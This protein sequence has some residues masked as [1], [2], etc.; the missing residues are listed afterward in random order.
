MQRANSA[1][2]QIHMFRSRFWAFKR[3]T[4]NDE[5]RKRYQHGFGAEAQTFCTR[6]ATERRGA[7]NGAVKSEARGAPDESFAR[8]RPARGSDRVVSV[9]R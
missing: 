8:S 5:V 1:Q 9:A 2:A 7:A 4:A 6:C 3:K